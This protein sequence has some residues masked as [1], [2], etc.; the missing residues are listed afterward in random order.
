MVRV[1]LIFCLMLAQPRRAFAC[2]LRLPACLSRVLHFLLRVVYAVRQR[3][4]A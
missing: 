1:L 3:G 4:V 2:C